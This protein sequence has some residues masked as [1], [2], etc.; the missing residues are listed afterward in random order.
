MIDKMQDHWRMSSLLAFLLA[1]LGACSSMPQGNSGKADTPEKALRAIYTHA[2]AE[3]YEGVNLHVYQHKFPESAKP[4]K[5]SQGAVVHSMQEKQPTTHT[6]DFSY[7][8]AAMKIL[9]DQHMDKFTTKVPSNH[10]RSV[11][12][13]G[14]LDA[15]L[16]EKTGGK[17]EHFQMLDHLGVHIL[18]VRLDGEYKLVFWEGL[19]NLLNS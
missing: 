19:N 2:L 1:T 7:S 10:L 9:L 15:F 18:M 5:Y 16:M 4:A 17:P 14:L 13:W 12:E 8:H 3:D 11:K 6:G